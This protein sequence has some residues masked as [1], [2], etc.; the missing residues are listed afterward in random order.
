MVEKLEKR[1][2]NSGVGGMLL[3]ELSKAFD[4]LRHDLLIAK[5]VAYGF[6]Q[7]SLCFIFSYPS[8]RT[9]RTKVNNSYSSHTDI[10]YG[11]PQCSILDPLLFNIDI[12]DLFFWDYKCDIVS[13]PDDNT[14]YTSERSLNLVL[15]KLE[16]STHDLFR[17][18]KENHMK[19]NPEKCHLLV[20]TN[21]LTSVNINGF[22]IKNSTEEKL[23]G[24]NFDSKLSF[25]NHV[26]SLYKEVTKITCT[27]QDCQLHELSKRKALMKAFVISQFNYCPLVWMFHSRKLRHRINSMHERALR[28]THQNYQATFLQLLQKGKSVTIHQRNLQVL[29][30]EI[31]KTKND[32]LPEIMKEVFELK[33]PS[34]SLRLKENYFVRGNV[35]TTHFGIQSIKSLALKIWDLVPDQIKHCRSLTK[36]KHFIKSSSP[37]DCP[38]RICKTHI[39]QVGFI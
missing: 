34:Y 35:K 1:L 31:F 38:Y 29:S 28:V 15:E 37:S 5:L 33:E 13:Y 7:P 23:L 18:F 6:H 30:T 3:A 19:A 9:Q 21:T 26:S 2:D 12:C 25:E 8:G 39:A 24:V 11:V 22:Q 14:P 27:N 16:S 10:K 4:C 32:L 36:L 17:W 20:T